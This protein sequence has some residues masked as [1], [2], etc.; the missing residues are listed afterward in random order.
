MMFIEFAKSWP[1]FI[2]RRREII[3]TYNVGLIIQVEYDP[4]L[5]TTY[6]YYVYTARQLFIYKS[7][8]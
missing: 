5:L 1:Q 8:Q 4:D 3:H 2:N 6:K 7:K